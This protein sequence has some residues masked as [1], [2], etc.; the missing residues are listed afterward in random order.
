M[1]FNQFMDHIVSEFLATLACKP[2]TMTQAMPVGL[3]HCG[4]PSSQQAVYSGGS[5]RS[6]KDPPVF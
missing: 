1:S 4:P 6:M 3:W 2:S 5:L